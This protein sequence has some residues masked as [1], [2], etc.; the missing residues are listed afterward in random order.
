VTLLLDYWL[1]NLIATTNQ[2]MLRFVAKRSDLAQRLDAWGGDVSLQ[3]FAKMSRLNL[4][5]LNAVNWCA[6]DPI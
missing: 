6:V 2:K 3:I 5:G 4:R 1:P